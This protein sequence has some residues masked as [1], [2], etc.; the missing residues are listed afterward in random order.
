MA[1]FG[2]VV[3]VNRIELTDEAVTYRC[4]RERCL[5]SPSDYTFDPRTT[6]LE[7][8]QKVIREHV[9]IAH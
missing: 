6:T 5:T 9:D 8:V 7:E 3:T 4:T 2:Y 1:P